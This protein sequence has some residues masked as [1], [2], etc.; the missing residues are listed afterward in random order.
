MVYITVIVYSFFHMDYWMTLCLFSIRFTFH[1]K[2]YLVNYLNSYP[3]K[4]GNP[5]PSFMK[6]V[7]S[8][9]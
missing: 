2:K 3:Q 6:Q 4:K 5:S 9:F 8:W 1:G 7:S